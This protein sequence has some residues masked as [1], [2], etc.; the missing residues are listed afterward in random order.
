LKL[1][2]ALSR[3]SV[4]V[5]CYWADQI[6]ASGIK[7]FLVGVGS[8]K[9]NIDNVEL[10]TGT[11]AWDGNPN[12]FYNS[13]YIINSNYAALGVM[14]L[15]VIKSLCQCYQNAPPCDNV[16]TTCFATQWSARVRITT[17]ATVSTT[18]AVN[19]VQAAN[20]YYYYVPTPNTRA[21]YEFFDPADSVTSTNPTIVRTDIQDPC[22]IQ[23][24][25]VSCVWCYHCFW[26]FA[27]LCF[28]TCG[29][30]CLTVSE[31]QDIPRFFREASD[32]RG[33]PGGIVVVG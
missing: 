4:G 32:L 20:L 11:R 10:I 3:Y 26:I 19:S 14:F 28:Q 6:K 5:P 9:G 13:D 18:F 33:A 24:L 2:F 21:A 25:V 12:T 27:K 7:I 16:A 29:S 15:N 31:R 30:R 17:T 1:T 22:K 8:V 23:R